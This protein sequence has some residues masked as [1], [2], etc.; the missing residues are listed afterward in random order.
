MKIRVL[1]VNGVSV[2]F[3]SNDYREANESKELWE[4]N[5]DMMTIMYPGKITYD[6]LINGEQ[7]D[8][9]KLEGMI[10]ES[11]AD[12]VIM[13]NTIALWNEKGWFEESYKHIMDIHLCDKIYENDSWVI[14]R[15]NPDYEGENVNG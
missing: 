13:R 6:T 2:Y 4:E 5:F 12:Y 10:L 3:G 7:G 8:F 1:Y 15:V 9:S 14:L 11:N